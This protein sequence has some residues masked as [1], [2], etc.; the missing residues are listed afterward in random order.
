[1][2][3]DGFICH[4]DGSCEGF[5]GEGVHVTDYLERLKQCDTVLMGRKTYEFGYEFGLQPGERAYPHMEHFIFSTTLHFDGG[6]LNIVEPDRIDVVQRMKQAQGGAIYLCGGGTLAHALLDHQLIDQ[7]VVKL[8]PVLF[9]SGIRAF[10]NSSKQ[11]GLTL[12]ESK[13]YD[14]GVSLLR[15]DLAYGS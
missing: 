5:V 11:V 6:Q 12:L 4:E 2:T 1:M 9:G 15:Y 14:N 7:L 8:N 3:L 13:S 10:G